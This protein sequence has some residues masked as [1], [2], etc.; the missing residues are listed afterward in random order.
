MPLSTENKKTA[1]FGMGQFVVGIF[2]GIVMCM[3]A[4]LVRCVLW[5]EKKHPEDDYWRRLAPSGATDA[6]DKGGG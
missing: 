6:Q 3:V 2:T 5:Y 4:M 1:G